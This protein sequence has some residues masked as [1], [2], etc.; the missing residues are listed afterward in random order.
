MSLAPIRFEIRVTRK[1]IKILSEKM[2]YLHMRLAKNIRIDIWIEVEA[3]TRWRMEKTLE[4][5]K[6]KQ[7]T[8]FEQ[9]Y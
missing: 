4:D 9:L 5:K 6:K 2:Y 1:S 8:K 7:N 3:A